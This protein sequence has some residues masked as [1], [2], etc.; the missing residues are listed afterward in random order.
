MR[1]ES[2][3]WSGGCWSGL[4]A[5]AIFAAGV[6]LEKECGLEKR[7]HEVEARGFGC[8]VARG[9]FWGSAAAISSYS[10]GLPGREGSRFTGGSGS[11][12]WVMFERPI[13]PSSKRYYVL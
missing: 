1:V 12:I 7:L 11:Q 9:G 5:T 6:S 4:P 3:R 8:T 10:F 13:S 2:L